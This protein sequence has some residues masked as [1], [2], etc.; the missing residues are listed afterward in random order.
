[1]KFKYIALTLILLTF[2]FLL[3]GCD[4]AK[5][6]DQFSYVIALGL[7]KGET[8]KLKLSLQFP[9][10]G[11]SEGGSSSQSSSS[12]TYSVECISIEDGINQMNNY[13]NKPINLL[14][15]KI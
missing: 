10:S 15:S 3:S 8:N 1:M 11:G 9:I 12:V 2:A 7:D 4:D 13:I 5:S 6:V 14:N